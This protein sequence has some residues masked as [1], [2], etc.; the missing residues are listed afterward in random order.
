M[1]RTQIIPDS[2]KISVV[3]PDNYIGKKVE[4]ILFSEDDVDEVGSKKGEIKRYKGMFSKEKA[5]EM[6][7]FAQQIRKEWGRE[8]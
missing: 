6:Q 1:I 3:V 5:L 8:I 2:N 7:E 4:V